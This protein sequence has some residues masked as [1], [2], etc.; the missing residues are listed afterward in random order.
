MSPD[1]QFLQAALQWDLPRLY[2][3][4]AK[5]KRKGLTSIE[6]V[7]L[8]GLLCGY[9]PAEIAE[10][11]NRDP[12][13]LKVDLSNRI[14]TYIKRLIGKE[15]EKMENWRNICEWLEEAGYKQQ[16]SSPAEDDIDTIPGEATLRI[17]NITRDK[18]I[19]EVKAQ[20][21]GSLS[22]TFIN[23]PT[24]CSGPNQ[25][26]NVSET[27]PESENLSGKDKQFE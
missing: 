12:E 14:Y 15:D 5:V 26:K 8:R 7:H 16:S 18:F 11:L 25:E 22:T 4:L 3:D 2:Q 21:I 27:S 6:R 1:E 23:F 24:I 17:K 9:S 20:F 10:K 19:F 13:G